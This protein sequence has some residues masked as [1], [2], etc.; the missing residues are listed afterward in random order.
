MDTKDK[1]LVLTLIARVNLLRENAEAN[2]DR[3]IKDRN[4]I[5][6]RHL[7]STSNFKAS[8]VILGPFF[9]TGSVDALSLAMS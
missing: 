7:I 2:R 5:M 9:W 3:E 8:F 4:I 1:P 6:T